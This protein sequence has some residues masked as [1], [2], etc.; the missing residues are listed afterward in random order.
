MH[1]VQPSNEA[2][3]SLVVAEDAHRVQTTTLPR[4][5]TTLHR[6]QTT[7]PLPSVQIGLKPMTVVKANKASRRNSTRI[8][9][10]PARLQGDQRACTILSAGFVRPRY[11]CCP[12]AVPLSALQQP[13][14]PG[15]TTRSAVVADFLN[16]DN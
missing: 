14:Q 1:S 2:E 6:V 10:L 9:T 5:Q 3:S 15:R 11:N 4:V 7:L 13:G 8:Q 12:P 16:V